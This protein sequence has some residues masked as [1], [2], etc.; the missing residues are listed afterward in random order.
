MTAYQ[1]RMNQLADAKKKRISEA[2]KLFEEGMTTIE[3]AERL[4]V[5]P[6]AVDVYLG[7]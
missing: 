5:K 7:E 4:G 2:K 6:A 1:D 3:I